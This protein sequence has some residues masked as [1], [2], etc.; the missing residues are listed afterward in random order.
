MTLT[1]RPCVL[2]NS[3]RNLVKGSESWCITANYQAKNSYGGYVRGS[4]TYYVN[5]QGL[6]STF[7]N[8]HVLE[9][10]LGYVEFP[11]DYPSVRL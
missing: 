4:S 6:H 2:T 7:L 3:F 8:Q 5:E 10:S 1:Q 9:S 11:D